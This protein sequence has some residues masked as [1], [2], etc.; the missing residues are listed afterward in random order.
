MAES[1][2][3][4]N[5]LYAPFTTEGSP[6]TVNSAI[7]NI[8]NGSSVITISGTI[9]L[10]SISPG[11]T[12]DILYYDPISNAISYGSSVASGWALV[13]NAGTSGAVL[14]STDP[15][16]WGLIV[17]SVSIGNFSTTISSL[18]NI[19]LNLGNNSS[20]TQNITIG[21]AA[22]TLIAYSVNAAITVSSGLTFNANSLITTCTSSSALYVNSVNVMNFASSG[23]SANL[24]VAIADA[25]IDGT[26]AISIGASSITALNLANPGCVTTLDGTSV[27]LP[28]LPNASDGY[29]LNYN[30]STFQISYSSAP[31]ASWLTSGGNTGAG[32]LLGNADTNS[33]S[34][35]SNS[36]VFF[37]VD[38][39]QNATFSLRNWAV[40]ASG[41]FTE[42][43]VSSMSI[44]QSTA[45]SIGIG[46]S[47]ATLSLTA[48]AF[49]LTNTTF[50]SSGT[51][52]TTFN[53]SEFQFSLASTLAVQISTAG[54]YS[55]NPMYCLDDL[56]VDGMEFLKGFLVISSVLPGSY[57]GL[58]GDFITLQAATTVATSGLTGYGSIYVDPTSNNLWF[59]NS[60]GQY[61]LTPTPSVLPGPGV[62]VTN[63][64]GVPSAVGNYVDTGNSGIACLY[65]GTDTATAANSGYQSLGIG[66]GALNASTTASPTCTAV[67]YGSQQS[68]S[69][70]YGNTSLGC[71]TLQGNTTGAGN[72]AIGTYSL[73][74][75]TIGSGN[76]A[77]GNLSLENNIDGNNNFAIGNGAGQSQTSCTGCIFFGVSSLASS[78]YSN[79]I[80]FGSNTTISGN[81]SVAFGYNASVTADNTISL[82]NGCSVVIGNTQANSSA[83]L[84]LESTAQGFLPPQMTTVQ[85]LA[86]S[87][88]AAGLVVYDNT[89][90]Q[91]SYYNGTT[92]I[93]VT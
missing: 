53:A 33:W 1:N 92:W 12:A 19:S 83:I 55:I 93:N 7:I 14:G 11:V 54:L 86:I 74:F 2:N 25:T 15:A 63:V 72:V 38:S 85:K 75:N 18:D 29:F 36:V 22:S 82:G 40:T 47:A 44:G 26:G 80:A 43:A 88:P 91:L 41:T 59:S 45:T 52:L 57:G 81:N 5:T 48:S 71:R 70:G 67:G 87:S 62:I 69:G 30:P 56:Y 16:S 20:L 3:S 9:N 58:T 24:T 34:M 32:L 6:F 35:R 89:L 50:S 90:N 66:Y 10:P 21:N 39:S 64:S 4:A 28:N 78:N 68:N 49:T 84:D 37:T 31:T 60:T 65:L 77:I 8:G 73:V 51:G 46:R 42:D 61:Q 79:S 76:I 23:I 13:G 17:N 27:Y